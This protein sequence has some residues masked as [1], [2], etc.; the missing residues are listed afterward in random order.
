M[1]YSIT[2]VLLNNTVAKW[3]IEGTQ[4]TRRNPPTRDLSEQAPIKGS[5]QIHGPLFCTIVETIWIYVDTIWT[6]CGTMFGGAAE[7]THTKHGSLFCT[8]A[9]TI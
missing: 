9:E 3:A 6:Q 5:E 1:C 8:I 4:I 7:R 2:G